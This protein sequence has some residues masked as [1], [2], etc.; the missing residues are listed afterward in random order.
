RTWPARRWRRRVELTRR[1][2][3]RDAAGA[4]VV[5]G[6]DYL[7]VVGDQQRLAVAGEPLDPPLGQAL[8][9][10]QRVARE[11]LEGR[12]DRLPEHE[13]AMVDARQQRERGRRE[14]LDDREHAVARQAHLGDELL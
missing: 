4:D 2:S 11:G 3:G 10:R 14:A 7:R 6:V 9:E 1:S 12:A 8:L 5:L 13:L